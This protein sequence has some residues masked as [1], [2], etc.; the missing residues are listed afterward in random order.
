MRL[1]FS[2]AMLGL[3][4]LTLVLP[5]GEASNLAPAIR[6]TLDGVQ[7]VVSLACVLVSAQVACA[8]RV[9]VRQAGQESGT[10]RPAVGMKWVPKCA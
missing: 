2:L 9:A 3:G 5:V 4:V 6:V 8:G 7:G 1:L 10:M